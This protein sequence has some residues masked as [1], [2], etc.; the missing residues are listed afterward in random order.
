MASRRY[1][2]RKKEMLVQQTFLLKGTGT[3]EIRSGDNND[4]LERGIEG[5][6]ENKVI[7]TCTW[8]RSVCERRRWDVDMSRSMISD[9]G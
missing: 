6:R 2:L 8:H 9:S 3:K 5:F 4:E 1:L 7:K